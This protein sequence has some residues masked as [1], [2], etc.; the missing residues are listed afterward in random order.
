MDCYPKRVHGS[1]MTFVKVWKLI[2]SF[3]C[4]KLVMEI[5]KIRIPF[6]GEDK[7]RWEASSNGHFTVK[8]I[9]IKIDDI[10]FNTISNSDLHQWYET[11]AFCMWSIWKARCAKSFDNVQ[12]NANNIPSTTM[13]HMNDWR[14]AQLAQPSAVHVL[15]QPQHYWTPPDNDCMK[16]NFDVS[17]VDNNAF[18]SWALISRN[19]AGDCDG[20]R[21]GA[22]HAIDPEQAEAQALLEAVLWAKQKGLTKLQLEGDCL[23]VISV[24]NG[25]LTAVKWTTHNLIKDALDILSSFSFWS[26]TYVHRDANHI[27]DSLAKFAR[28]QIICFQY[29]NDFP[30]WIQTLIQQDKTLI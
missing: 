20:L 25:S 8:S 26:C 5:L 19:S 1:G 2:K 11:A 28:S 18:S 12:P 15:T 27:A 13:V 22:A 24:V 7:L 16:L 17:F 4:G 14:S 6:N 3:M 10:L 21:G 30:A 23:N 29:Y 9:W